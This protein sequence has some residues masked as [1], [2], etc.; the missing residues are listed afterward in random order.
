MTETKHD[1]V[2][3]GAGIFGMATAYHILKNNENLKVMVIDKAASAG[4]GNT[5]Q[6]AAMYRDTFSSEVNLILSS[7]TRDFFKHV[8]NEL[9]MNLSLKD[10]TYLWLM[11]RVQ[12]EG[13]KHAV[14][15]M[16]EN[17][18]RI[19]ILDKD[20]IKQKIPDIVT[21]FNDAENV[22]LLGLKNI[23]FGIL[24]HDCGELDA[25][26]ITRDFYETEFKKLGGETLYSTRIKKLVLEPVGENLGIPG[27]PVGWQEKK[28]GSIETQD[29]KKIT[30]ETFILATGPW[31]NELLLPIGVDSHSLPLKKS[32]FRVQTPRL[33]SLLDNK[34][35]NE[36][37]TIPFIIF[38]IHGIYIKP[39]KYNN[40]VWIGGG[41]TIGHPYVISHPDTFEK[42]ENPLD[43][44]QA[45]PRVY[46][47]DQY[48]VLSEY[49]P[50][51][52]NQPLTNQWAGYYAM[53]TTDKN[54]VVFKPNG[55][56]GLIV[57]T[58]GSGS[59]IMKADAVGRIADALYCGKEN[60]EL[61]GGKEFKVSR[62][63]LKSRDVDKEDFVI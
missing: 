25:D 31:A 14:E 52:K 20:D 41:S 13:N 27:E 2:I 43:D 36:E 62:L 19:E 24:G 1:V 63:G 23:D 55:I 12:F 46:E 61:F 60:A 34:N 56:K 49:L 40:S 15:A 32:L 29:G 33:A 26:K 11:D 17:N 57:V 5:A 51:L 9:G 54:P 47:Y 3:I 44:T 18:I 50:V 37:E 39:V 42:E 38:P 4:S 59:G 8:Q 16:L 53:N 35:F 48:L 10:I 28:V 7:T 6:S 22:E 58:S 21:D 45:D 30:S